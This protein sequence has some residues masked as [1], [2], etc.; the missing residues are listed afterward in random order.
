MFTFY[1]VTDKHT[2]SHGDIS[3]TFEGVEMMVS[4]ESFERSLEILEGKEEYI[5]ILPEGSNPEDARCK[6]EMVSG[7]SDYHGHER[8][9]TKYICK[10]L[11][12]VE[13]YIKLF[14]VDIG[15]PMKIYW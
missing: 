15:N 7:Y 3:K 2:L 10:T 1:T 6:W 5:G 13:E 4:K 14:N 8:V 9:A 11:D 12:A